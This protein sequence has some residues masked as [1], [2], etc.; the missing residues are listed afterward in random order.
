MINESPPAHFRMAKATPEDISK[1]RYFLEKLDEY[2]SEGIDNDEDFILDIMGDF[3]VIHG[4][5]RVVEGYQVLVDNACDPALDYLEF[6][7]EIREKSMACDV[8]IR[9]LVY[10]KQEAAKARLALDLACVK[11]GLNRGELIQDVCCQEDGQKII[12]E[13][14]RLQ[15]EATEDA[16]EVTGLTINTPK[17]NTNDH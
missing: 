10:L 1:L 15:V 17:E 9:K 5:R 14:Q 4:W 2:Q 16:I 3:E 8:L 13:M 12:D 7:P 6:K 11:S